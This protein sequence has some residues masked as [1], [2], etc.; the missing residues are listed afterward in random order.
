M[1]IEGT[2]ALG[3]DLERP[4][5]E[6]GVIGD[7]SPCRSSRSSTSVATT[8]PPPLCG[9]LRRRETPG[10]DPLVVARWSSSDW[11][12]RTSS[13]RTGI[14]RLRLLVARSTSCV[15]WMEA[16]AWADSRSRVRLCPLDGPDDGFAVI[17]TGRHVSWSDPAADALFLQ[18]TGKAGRQPP[19]RLSHS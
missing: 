19:G 18:Q 1:G 3:D 4:L 5:S 13:R 15:T 10:V 7:V 2:Q 6:I 9:H 14:T 17:G 8:E 11:L 16:L 12:G